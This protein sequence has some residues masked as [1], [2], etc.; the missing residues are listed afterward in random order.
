M[1]KFITSYLKNKEIQL[2]N[3]LKDILDEDANFVRPLSEFW[4]NCSKDQCSLVNHFGLWLSGEGGSKID[5]EY[6]AHYYDSDLYYGSPRLK[7]F[8]DKHD[9]RVYWYDCGTPVLIFKADYIEDE[10]N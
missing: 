1:E 4:K 8:M 5:G 2:V 7:E 6:A 10:N 3:E 9:L